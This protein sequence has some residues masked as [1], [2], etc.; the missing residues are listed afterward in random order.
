MIKMEYE[1]N[2]C[3]YCKEMI[4]SG[5]VQVHENVDGIETAYHSSCWKHKHN[6]I[7][8]LNFEV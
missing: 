1:I 4:S 3:N 2:Y 8:E 5:A 6:N 7:E